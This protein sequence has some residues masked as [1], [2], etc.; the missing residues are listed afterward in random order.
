MLFKVKDV[1]TLLQTLDQDA[2]FALA[3]IYDD[4]EGGRQQWLVSHLDKLQLHNFTIDRVSDGHWPHA[5]ITGNKVI[6]DFDERIMIKNCP[7]IS[8]NPDEIAEET[9]LD[10]KT[11]RYDITMIR[12]NK[13]KANK[14]LSDVDLLNE[15]EIE[16]YK[17]AVSRMLNIA[18]IEKG[19][20]AAE[21]Q[22]ISQSG[23]ERLTNLISE[24]VGKAPARKLK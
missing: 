17:R 3:D 8:L 13:E 4:P 11:I 2:I 19:R 1:I 22:R 24:P 14:K 10:A 7:G 15:K 23:I 18:I 5:Y 6:K 21:F 16:I 20:T 12:R 9:G